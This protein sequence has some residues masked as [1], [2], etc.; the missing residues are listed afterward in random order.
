[1]RL[2]STTLVVQLIVSRWDINGVVIADASRSQQ[3]GDTQTDFQEGV[4]SQN[5]LSLAVS[6]FNY[7]VG[8]AL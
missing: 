5:S 7:H 8:C 2:L 6:R 3:E 1:M 4:S